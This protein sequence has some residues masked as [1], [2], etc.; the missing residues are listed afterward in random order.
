MDGV[1][2]AVARSDMVKLLGMAE[3]ASPADERLIAK[4]R[5]ELLND[6]AAI[7][8]IQQSDQ[9]NFNAQDFPY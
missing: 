8:E 2:M 3:P 4:I 1:G 7:G 6:S 5:R 9:R